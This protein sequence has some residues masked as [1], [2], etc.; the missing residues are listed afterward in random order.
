MQPL[1]CYLYALSVNISNA[2]TLNLPKDLHLKGDQENIALT[3]FFVPY[4]LFEVPSNV[5]MRRL[6][7]HIWCKSISVFWILFLGS[8]LTFP[9]VWMYVSIW[10]CDAVSRFW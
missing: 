9:S 6:K 10:Y 3:I 7:P 1:E 4:I 8:Y 5:L 2:L